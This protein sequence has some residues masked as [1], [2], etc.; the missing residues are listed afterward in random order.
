VLIKKFWWGYGGNQK[1]MHWVNWYK[2]CLAKRHG[3]MGFRNM[4][5]F[6]NSLLAKQVWRLI[7]NDKSLFCKVFKARFFMHGSILD[8]DVKTNG[9]YAWKSIIQARSVS[10]KRA[11]W[12]IGS[13]NQAKI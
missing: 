5:K 10:Q 6:N 4:R 3:G 1:K 8:D 7:H 13:G 9:S 12:R 11:L 2:M